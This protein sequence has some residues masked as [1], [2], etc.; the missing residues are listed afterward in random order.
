MFHVH[1]EKYIYYCTEKIVYVFT[2]KTRS[3][4]QNLKVLFNLYLEFWCRIIETVFYILSS[5]NLKFTLLRRISA[6]NN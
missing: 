5:I 3:I 2:V 1:D 6:L 4:R